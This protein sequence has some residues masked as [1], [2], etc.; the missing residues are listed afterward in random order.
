MRRGPSA[1]WTTLNPVLRSGEQGFES[2]TG[3]AKVGDGSTAWN[4]LPYVGAPT[5]GVGAPA[6]LAP[7]Q[8]YIELD[9][10]GAVVGLWLGQ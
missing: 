3:K 6:S 9:A 8:L 4:A 5:A 2:D 10:N 7:G 1:D